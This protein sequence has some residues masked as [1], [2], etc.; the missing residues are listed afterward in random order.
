V[1]IVVRP[2]AEEDFAEVDLDLEDLEE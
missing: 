2:G 1:K